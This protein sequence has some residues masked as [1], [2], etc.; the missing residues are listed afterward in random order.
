MLFCEIHPIS[1]KNVA[2]IWEADLGQKTKD[3]PRVIK[4]KDK[5]KLYRGY[6]YLMAS[7]KC[8]LS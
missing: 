4:L 5:L 8:E 6:P 1:K 3:G 7:I 2:Y